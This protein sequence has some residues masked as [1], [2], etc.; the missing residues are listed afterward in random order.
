MLGPL[1][2]P[3][4]RHCGKADSTQGVKCRCL[5]CG[6]LLL[7][8][9]LKYVDTP[10]PPRCDQKSAQV[11][12]SKGVSRAPLRKRVRNLLKM[13]G[14]HVCN[15]KQ[16]ASRGVAAKGCLERSTPAPDVSQNKS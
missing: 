10:H 12:E 11:Y 7:I 16:K 8:S 5:T 6:A 4:S 3:V 13:H 1:V 14:L 9:S 15:K 2:T